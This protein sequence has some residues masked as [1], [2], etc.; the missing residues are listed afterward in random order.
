MHRSPAVVIVQQVP[1]QCSVCS[2]SWIIKK[3]IFICVSAV[4]F[5]IFA[6]LK[7][8]C[9]WLNCSWVIGCC[10]KSQRVCEFA[11]I[12]TKFLQS[13]R[14][15][16]TAWLVSFVPLPCSVITDSFRAS[17]RTSK[18]WFICLSKDFVAWIC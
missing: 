2:F 9:C 5:N 14:H 18:I 13:Y 12:S 6:L 1:E 4:P 17:I 11:I 16:R 8:I 7:H 3:V 10:H 15:Y